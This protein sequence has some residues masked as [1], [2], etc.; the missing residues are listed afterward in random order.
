MKNPHLAFAFGVVLLALVGCQREDVAVSNTPKQPDGSLELR[1]CD[2]DV[3]TF[4]DDPVFIDAY[5]NWRTGIIEPGLTVFE[6]MDSSYLNYLVARITICLE[7]RDD[8]VS[9]L[10]SVNYLLTAKGFLETFQLIDS[11]NSVLRDNYDYLSDEEFDAI[12]FE[13]L[14]QSFLEDADEGLR[15]LPCY[16]EFQRDIIKALTDFSMTL[17]DP[18]GPARL[19]R[20]FGLAMYDYCNCMYSNY[21]TG[22]PFL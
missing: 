15:G 6:A 22:C 2:G 12:Y 21:N 10:D 3:N 5:F 11:L 9:C 13:A 20:D 17:Y 16:E 8:I 19:A 4:M 1:C 7:E 18:L 14:V